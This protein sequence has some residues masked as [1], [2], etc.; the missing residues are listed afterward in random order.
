LLLLVRDDEFAW[1]ER[2][3]QECLYRR[4]RECVKREAHGRRTDK[5]GMGKFDA[6]FKK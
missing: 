1:E 4:E 6:G 3:R 5:L 2:D